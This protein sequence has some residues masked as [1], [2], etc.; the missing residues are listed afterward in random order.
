MV[1]R[2]AHPRPAVQ[3]DV[4][5]GQR[6]PGRSFEHADAGVRE[7][8]VVPDD[9]KVREV[10][11]LVQNELLALE[12]HAVRV[13]AGVAVHEVEGLQGLGDKPSNVRPSTFVVG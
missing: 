7:H 10:E 1:G 4:P 9:G 3:R 11:Q 12:L 6:A 2:V 5:D 13:V 8:V